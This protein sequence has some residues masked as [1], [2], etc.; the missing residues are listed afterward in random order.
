MFARIA[1]V[2][3]GRVLALVPASRYIGHAV[4]DCTG[5]A[6][7]SFATW[8]LEPNRPYED[9]LRL[10]L[11][12]L[13]HSLRVHRP[14]VLV[15]GVP[16]FDNDRLRVFRRIA[17]KLATAHGVSVV[18]RRV[19]DARRLLFGRT[20][21]DRL[22]ALADR[23]VRGFFPQLA[24][25]RTTG[26][27]RRYHRNAFSAAAVALHELVER[28]PLSAAVIAKNEAFAMG[29]FNAALAESARR[30]FPDNL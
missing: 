4:L 8:N 24:V 1:P 23:L 12:C 2:H 20:R 15:L 3:P 6:P 30:H 13:H 18:A 22:D 14:A 11:L 16:R 29:R 27:A 21:G 5:L 17:A 28:A 7:A 10:F 19:D 9:R 26:E 25:P